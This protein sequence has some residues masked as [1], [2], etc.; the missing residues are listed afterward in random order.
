MV[1]YRKLRYSTVDLLWPASIAES[2]VAYDFG[3]SC[4]VINLV[5]DSEPRVHLPFSLVYTSVTINGLITS[6]PP[7]TANKVILFNRIAVFINYF[8]RN[9]MDIG[10]FIPYAS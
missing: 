6:L 8:N 7:T 4:G 3:A 1:C 9:F 10:F 5:N 2:N